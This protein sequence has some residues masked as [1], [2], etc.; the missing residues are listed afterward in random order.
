[1]GGPD[2]SANIERFT[3]FASQY[4][5]VRPGPPAEL[6]SLLIPMARCV[7]P[8]LVVDLGS[9]TG[10]STR[11]WSAHSKVVIGVEPS[12]SMRNEAERT[13]CANVSYRSGLSHDTALPPKCADIVVCGQSLHWMDPNPTFAECVRILRPGG[14]FAAYDYDW[15]PATSFWEV[16]LAYEECMA[17]ARDLE[18]RH[19]VTEGLR[20]WDKEG[21][22]RRMR[23]SGCFRH[24]FE[25]LLSHRDKGDAERYVGLFLSQGYVRSLL[26]AGLSE[27]DLQIPRLRSVADDAFGFSAPV[28]HW[29]ARVRIGIE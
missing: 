10:L 1:M 11:Y 25:C 12:G 18:K 24:V 21:H 23:E 15:P 2:F 5:D 26:K 7:T 19:N 6:A 3:G 14:V 28:W 29:S 9:G 13:S 4:N 20:Q 27:D 8:S 22:L 17:R 16:D